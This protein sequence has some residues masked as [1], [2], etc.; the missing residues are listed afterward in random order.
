MST[1]I[2]DGGTQTNRSRAVTPP[3]RGTSR[4]LYLLFEQS[5]P[6]REQKVEKII[7]KYLSRLVIKAGIRL[8]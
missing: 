6:F 8:T 1:V 3:V 2:N 5:T 7:V 4:N